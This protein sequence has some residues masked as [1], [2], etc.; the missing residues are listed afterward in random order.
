MTPPASPPPRIMAV[1]G[2]HGVPAFGRKGASTH[3]REM[4]AAF[5]RRGCPVMLAASD[6]SGDRRDEEDFPTIQLPRPRAKWLGFDGR[7][8]VADL[9]ARRHLRR[10]IGEFRPDLVYERSALYFRA[11]GRV[12]RSL[13]VPRILEVNTLL[14]HELANRLKFPAWARS[15][16]ARL[17]RSADGIAAISGLM[18]ERLHHEVGIPANRTRVFTMAVD[19]DRFLPPGAR[20]NTRKTMGASLDAHVI[21]YV[22]S[23]NHYHKPAWFFDAMERLAG[24]GHAFHLLVVGGTERKIEQFKTRLRGRAPSIRAYFTGPVPQ[25]RMPRWI[26]CMDLVVVPGA[27]PQ[28]TP[29]K[30]FEVAA[31]GCPLLVPDTAPIREICGGDAAGC[32]FPADDFDALVGRVRAWLE[33][34]ETLHAP[35]RALHQRVLADYTWDRHAGRVIDW[36]REIE[37]DADGPG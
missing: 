20:D 34:P 22:G 23:M 16:E 30:I 17:L 32:L 21:G 2:D 10:A 14:S 5:R 12:A 26:E 1:C 15:A 31:I 24:E 37:S 11:G 27:A 36:W 33:N 7:Y 13:G 19:P 29:T 3:L 35:A 6:L 4:I 18:A 8:V 28:S 25:A 9:L